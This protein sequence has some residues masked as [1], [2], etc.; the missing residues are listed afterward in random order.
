MNI[1][2]IEDTSSVDKIAKAHCDKHVVKMILETAQILSTVSRLYGI[3]QGY[4]PTHKSHPVVKW[5]TESLENWIWTKNLGLALCSEY[6]HRYGKIHKTQAVLESLE[7]PPMPTIGFTTPP[8]CVPDEYRLD[9]D[10][11]VEAYRKYYIFEKGN[12]AKW[13]K[14]NP[15]SWFIDINS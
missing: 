7:P 4:K 6:T 2:F 5:A 3:E 11:F 15:P 14:R 10:C 9:K 12:I 13:S 1:F 8:Q